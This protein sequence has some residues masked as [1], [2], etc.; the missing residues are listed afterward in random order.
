M[1]SRQR[2]ALGVAR[3]TV[4]LAVTDTVAIAV[5]LNKLRMN[6]HASTAALVWTLNAYPLAYAVLLP[7]GAALG[8]RYGHGCV[9]GLGLGLAAV[10]STGCAAACTI[11]FLIAWRAVQGAACAL[12]VSAAASPPAGLLPPEAGRRPFSGAGVTLPT[13]GLLAGGVLVEIGGWRWL[14]AAGAVLGAVGAVG[15]R[16]WCGSRRWRGY[17]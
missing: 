7:C 10:A 8:A 11:G 2:L 9:I 17:R 5:A 15:A 3:L 12:A 13:A 14:F 4:S 16:R 6:L 1:T